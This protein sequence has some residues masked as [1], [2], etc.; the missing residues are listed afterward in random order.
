MKLADK[1]IN[2][3]WK[4]ELEKKLKRIA[5]EIRKNQQPATRPEEEHTREHYDC[6]Y[7]PHI[8]GFSKRS[9]KDLK[10]LKVGFAFKTTKNT[11][12]HGM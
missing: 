12:L 6:L 10:S 1:M 2:Q 5:E 4:C 11:V 7:A 8:E 9:Q 3:P